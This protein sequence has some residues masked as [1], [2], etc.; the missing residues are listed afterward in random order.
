MADVF[1]K[2]QRSKCMA[3]VR[4]RG[5]KATELRLAAILRRARISGWRRHAPV[6]GHPDFVFWRERVAVFVDGCFWHGCPSHCR[7]PQDNRDYWRRKIG[8][9]ASRDTR[10]NRLL[11]TRGWRVVRIWAHSLEAPRAVVRRIS[12]ALSW[13]A[14]KRNRDQPGH[15]PTPGLRGPSGPQPRE[16]A[17]R[18]L[19][20]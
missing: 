11:R 10:T 20:R 19:G 17:G 14:E 5:N 8:G 2:K 7:M 16:N 3:A 9:N 6:A 12:S 18:R 15:C 1:T 13:M 4:S